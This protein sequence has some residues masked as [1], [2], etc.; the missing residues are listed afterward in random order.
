MVLYAIQLHFTSMAAT[1]CC[2]VIEDE[3]IAFRAA[4]NDPSARDRNALF[5]PLSTL[6]CC[7]YLKCINTHSR[8]HFCHFTRA[9][10]HSVSLETKK[11]AV[12]RPSVERHVLEFVL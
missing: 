9:F 3:K 5:P 11:D 6:A 10:S 7:L 1:S 12:K 2:N 4:L 8:E